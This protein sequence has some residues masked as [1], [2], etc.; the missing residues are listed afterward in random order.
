MELDNTTA[1][2]QRCVQTF[3]TSTPPS[4]ALVE[5]ISELR[6]DTPSDLEPPLFD[7]LDPDAFDTL[8]DSSAAIDELSLELAEY[9]C[10][11]QVT[12]DDQLEIRAVGYA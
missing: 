9:D 11:V 8:L 3:D 1:N 10:R 12:L 5:S 7:L 4:V 2:R 6:D